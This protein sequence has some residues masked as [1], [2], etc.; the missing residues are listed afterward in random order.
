MADSIYSR[1]VE[2]PV[3]AEEAFNWHER[4]GAL[5]RLIPPWELVHVEER[6]G[7]IRDGDRVT[8]TNW[9]GPMKFRW[10]AEHCDYEAGRQF[11]DIQLSGPFARWE[12]THRF[13][14]N[15]NGL[16]VLEDQVEYRVPCGAIGRWLGGRFI[17]RKIDR[18]FD[19]RHST[20]V[21][22]LSAH[23]RHAERGTLH[24]AVTGSSGL[25]GSTLVPLLTT[26]GHRVTPLVRE[27]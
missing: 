7:G 22:D 13:T 21:A 19:Y 8:L 6:E 10:I 5:E 4:P 17:Q 27:E 25:V 9:L 15:G 16:G 14:T 26:G 20:T 18:M 24:V 23:A 3:T 2:L 1:T 12:H 11:R